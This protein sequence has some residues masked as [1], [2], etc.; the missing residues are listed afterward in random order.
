MRAL[1]HAAKD[2]QWISVNQSL[3]YIENVSEVITSERDILT[4]DSLAHMAAIV[5]ELSVLKT[6]R[7]L[8]VDL[9]NLTNY[10]NRSPMQEAL[11]AGS[12]ECAEWLLYHYY[13]PGERL[14]FSDSSFANIR[15]TFTQQPTAVNE[16]LPGYNGLTWA[17]ICVEEGRFRELLWLADHGADLTVVDYLGNSL[18][19]LLNIP[20]VN[21]ESRPLADEEITLREETVMAALDLCAIEMGCAPMNSMREDERN[22]VRIAVFLSDKVDVNCRN[23]EGLT[24]AGCIA[25]KS[26]YNAHLGW[27]ILRILKCSGADLTLA[28]DEKRDTAMLLASACGDGPWLDWCVREGGC[29]PNAVDSKSESDN[30]LKPLRSEYRRLCCVRR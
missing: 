11:Q 21:G 23:K 4:G 3:K 20:P 29:N 5:G 14:F 10:S 25:E 27:A 24:P 13:T 15:R 1:I 12:R 30:S 7:K 19:H 6:L 9:R 16:P 28:D 8:G 26:T 17:G 22:V 18:L 2:G